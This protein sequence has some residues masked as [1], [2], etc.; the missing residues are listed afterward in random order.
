MKAI[1]ANNATYFIIFCLST[2]FFV[3]IEDVISCLEVAIVFFGS[4]VKA[5]GFE[6]TSCFLNVVIDERD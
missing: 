4:R 3:V 2:F 1:E 6:K 5:R